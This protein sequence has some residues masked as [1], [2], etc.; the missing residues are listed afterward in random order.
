[1]RNKKWLILSIG[2]VIDIEYKKGAF[3][4][5][6]LPEG[7]KELV[8]ALTESQA[9]NKERFDDVNRGNGPTIV[10]QQA[11]EEATVFPYDNNIFYFDHADY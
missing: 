11:H 3:H 9:A 8:L 7:H 4:G 2:S 1:M 5:L 6:V 10:F